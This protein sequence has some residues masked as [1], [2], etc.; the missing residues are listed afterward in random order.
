MCGIAGSLFNDGREI[1]PERFDSALTLMRHRGPDDRGSQLWRDSSSTGALGQTRLSI[2]DLTPGGHQ[3]MDSADGSMT[4]V[5]NGELYNY[6]ELR[7]QLEARGRRFVSRSDTE[8]LLQAWQEWGPESLPMLTGMFAFALLDRTNGTLTCVR[9]A[10]GIKPLYWTLSGGG[11]HFASEVGAL[12]RLT[13]DHPKPDHQQMYDY[14]VQAQY[15]YGSRTFTEGVQQLPAG[16]LLTVPIQK[17]DGGLEPRRW[18]WPS[19]EQRD[20]PFD[21]AAHQLRELFLDSV[22]LH[23]R[24]DVPVGAALSGGIDSSS[25]VGAM[26]H[27]EPDM[28]IHTFTYSAAG[29]S[30]DEA[31]WAQTVVKATGA[32]QHTVIVDAKDLARDLDDMILAQGEPFGSTS[33][34]AQYSVYRRVRER[35]IIV[36]LDGQG[37]DELLAGYHGYPGARLAS[38]LTRGQVAEAA[39]FARAWSRW[40]GRSLAPLVRNFGTQLAPAWANRVGRSI[41]GRSRAPEWLDEHACTEVGILFHE[42]QRLQERTVQ[43]RRLAQQ[44][45]HSLTSGDLTSLLRHG[46][47]NSM[48]WSVESRVPFLTTTLAE[49]TLSLPEDYLVSRDGETKSVFRAAMT[50]IVPTEVLRRRDKVGFQTPED[51]WLRD[52][53]PQISEWLNGLSS[54]PW[55]RLPEARQEVARIIDGERPFSWQ[56]WRLINAARWMQLQS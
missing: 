36:T 15:D 38:L 27:L 51:L 21:E 24:S 19:I 33:I 26:R 12:L 42:P 41:Y 55:I 14:L 32:L 28:P 3:P 23:L 43:G 30:I 16:H 22:R 48:R 29:A 46:D 53:R 9:D 5:Y 8:V 1:L 47:R 11:F 25:I 31:S 50:G 20:I 18:W 2:I 40:P 34:F 52:L 49:F 44:L 10:F 6:R 37:A 56:A 4:V 7:S 45:R 54:L 13:D 35:G 17:I 39:R